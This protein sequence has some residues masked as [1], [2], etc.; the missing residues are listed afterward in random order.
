MYFDDYWKPQIK[1]K[2]SLVVHMLTAHSARVEVALEN[3]CSLQMIVLMVLAK[4]DIALMILTVICINGT[5]DW[6]WIYVL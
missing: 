1:K 4:E 3:F 6:I 5:M 2:C